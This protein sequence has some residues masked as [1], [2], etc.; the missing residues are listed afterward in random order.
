MTNDKIIE[1]PN[2]KKKF[3]ITHFHKLN[4]P[5]GSYLV[6]IDEFLFNLY[7]KHEKK[8]YICSYVHNIGDV[9]KIRNSTNSIVKK[10]LYIY[11]KKIRELLN[12][13]HKNN[14]SEKYWGLIIDKFLIILLKSI[15]KE[16]KLYEN[17][18]IN[19][20]H[21]IDV[22]VKQKFF[23]D[24]ETLESY[25][26]SDD[27]RNLLS[28][29]V[30]KE[31]NK[32]FVKFKY[33]S[34]NRDLD[35]NI[36][37]KYP[38][39][40]KFSIK[41][42]IFLFKPILIIN[43]HIG[44]INT[45]KFFLRSFGKI[46]NV[47]E[48]LFFDKL[49]NNNFLD[50]GFRKN[51]KI[52]KNKKNTVDIIFN[53]IVYN[54]LPK[55][56]L[57]NFNLIKRDIIK[58]SKKVKVIGT[59]N[60][61]YFSDHFNI[62]ASEILKSKKGKFVIFQHGGAISKT[63]DIA[64]EYLDQKYAS[65]KYYFDN[66]EGLGMHFFRGKKISPEEIKN[67]ND[68]LILNTLT[69]FENSYFLQSSRYAHLDPS[70]V[71]YSKLNKF[72][73]KKVFLKLFPENNSFQIKNIWFRKF[74]NKINFLPIYSSAIKSKFYKAKL[75]ILNDIS[76]ALWELIYIGIPFILICDKN[77][78][79]A[80]QYKNSFYKKIIPL[81]KINVLFDDPLKAADFVNSLNKDCLIDN[82]WLNI[83]KMDEFLD[84]KNFLI[85]EKPNYISRIVKNLKNLNK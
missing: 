8:I 55:N 69:T 29:L 11:R 58:I 45:L 5:N 1:I 53:K 65:K 32:N 3:L 68:I 73:K 24:I 48:K 6:F 61:H 49:Y 30:L 76:T 4:Y 35:E 70:L 40:V 20:F 16:I 59:G 46:I 27:F 84:F 41:L 10:K 22:S 12:Y 39:F 81:K 74:S 14:N 71:F 78:F 26:H 66:K 38:F 85:V 34:I 15:I 9:I 18:K 83:S 75:V 54:L 36:I 13:Y 80:W 62:L 51:I 50:L 33:I 44:L 17:I 2:K 42:Y 21:K 79:S 63:K 67:R 28:S 25:V 82:W 72:N 77:I 60:C 19:D 31:I 47:P 64:L 57:E 23:N 52:N 7:T 56:Y 37:N 43:G